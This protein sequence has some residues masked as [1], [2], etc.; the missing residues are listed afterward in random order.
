MSKKHDDVWQNIE[1]VAKDAYDKGRLDVV[2]GLQ[3]GIKKLNKPTWTQTEI[4]LMLQV[5]KD[6]WSKENAGRD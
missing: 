5:L 1:Q 4:L 6:K 3:E 2:E